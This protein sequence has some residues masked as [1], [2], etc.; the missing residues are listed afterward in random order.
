MNSTNSNEL[1]KAT[2]NLNKTT[3]NDKTSSNNNSKNTSIEDGKN[4]NNNSLSVIT[5]VKSKS[6]NSSN[7]NASVST[8]VTLQDQIYNSVSP[9]IFENIT[10]DKLK[11]VLSK[12]IASFQKK[13]LIILDSTVNSGTFSHI[14][15]GE[16]KIANGNIKKY[17]VKIVNIL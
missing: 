2:K 10:D 16:Q 13:S 12:E 9:K 17:V 5:S 11:E 7:K 14:F 8:Q 1:N 15:L 6:D 3:N 4:P